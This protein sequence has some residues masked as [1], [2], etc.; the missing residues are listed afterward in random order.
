MGCIYAQRKEDSRN[1]KRKDELACAFCRAPDTVT[2]KES[3][4]LV[5][6][7]VE[8][9]NPDA[10]NMLASCYMY[11]EKGLPRDVTKAKELYLK[12]GEL[13]C[14][15]GY[16]NLAN[17]YAKKG[18]EK[19]TRKER[20]YLELGT[21]AGDV[22][23]RHN[24]GSLEWRS[25]SYEKA[26]KHWMISSKGGNEMSLDHVQVAFKKGYVSKDEYTETLRA[27]QQYKENTKSAMRDEFLVYNPSHKYSELE[28]L[29]S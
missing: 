6:K 13:G 15:D 24:L 20:Q 9:N 14:G 18:A 1:G 17:I 25:G 2:E 4:M 27:Y 21:I 3:I 10:T 26:C 28:R 23:A 7:A 29:A 8:K 5:K 16:Y 22:Y 19:D 12:A 11:G